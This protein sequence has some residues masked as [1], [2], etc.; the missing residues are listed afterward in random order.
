MNMEDTAMNITITSGG[1]RRRPRALLL[2]AVAVVSALTLAACSGGSSDSSS[3]SEGPG[4]ASAVVTDAMGPVTEID[5]PA[6][7]F[8]PP[9]G[10]HILIMP[11]SSAGQGCVDEAEEEK[12]DR[13]STRLNSSH[14]KISYAVFCLKKKTH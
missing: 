6:D 7:S 2:T 13:K 10:K 9:T 8:T 4:E 12:R 3:T 11:C 1:S 5:A 14:V